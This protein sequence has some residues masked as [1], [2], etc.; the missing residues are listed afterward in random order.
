MMSGN[1]NKS[2]EW[3]SLKMKP[4]R[5]LAAAV[6]IFAFLTAAAGI[7]AAT[8]LTVTGVHKDGTEN[9]VNQYR[10]VLEEDVTFRINPGEPT[11][12]ILAVDFHKSYMPVVAQ[13][14]DLTALSSIALDADKYYYVSVIPKEPGTYSIGGAGFKGDDGSVEVFLNELPLPTAQ[15]TIYVHEDL[16]PI[17]NVWDEGEPGLAGFRI[18][19]EDAGGR[20]GISAGVQSQDAFGNPLGT[21][22]LQNCDEFGQATDPPGTGTFFCLDPEGN[23]IVDIAGTG[24]LLTG[25]D[26]SLTIKNLAQANTAS[27]SSRPMPSR[28]L[29][30]QGTLSVTTGCRRPPSRAPSSLMPGSRPMSRLSLPSS[31]RPAPIPRSASCLRARAA[32][33]STARRS[34]EGPLFP[35]RSST[36]TYPGRRR[37]HSIRARLFPTPGPG[38][39]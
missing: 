5:I 3:I 26:G 31:V 23:P 24:L 20:Y 10:W 25:P 28:V 36:F 30:V 13:G 7:G 39:A 32:P 29:R 1:R 34:A 15:I 16:N 2:I 27:S 11:A 33:T 38:S 8:S 12:D 4:T 14:D 35:G 9:P 18:I 22:Y 21:T 37:P 6:M 17:N 19:L